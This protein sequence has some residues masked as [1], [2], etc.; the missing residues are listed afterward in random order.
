M[1]LVISSPPT[2]IAGRAPGT[3]ERNET[4][5]FLLDGRMLSTS[6]ESTVDDA[7]DT[8]ST[9]GDA[10]DTVT[11]SWSEP[12]FSDMS[13]FATNPAASTMPSR[14]ADWK[15]GRENSTV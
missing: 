10:P 7:L 8:T 4:V 6:F 13:I 14:R 11:D 9:T 15:L 12:T 2:P 3:Y 1:P 5:P